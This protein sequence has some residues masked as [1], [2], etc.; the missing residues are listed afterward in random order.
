VKLK[1]PSLSKSGQCPVVGCAE[2]FRLVAQRC[3]D[4]VSAGCV[5]V[6]DYR[7]MH[8]N[9]SYPVWAKQMAVWSVSVPFPFHLC[10]QF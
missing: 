6:G 3:D 2:V 5:A 1:W 7:D 9:V 8:G 4:C 10:G